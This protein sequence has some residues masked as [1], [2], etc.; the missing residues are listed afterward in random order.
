MPSIADDIFVREEA[1]DL[2]RR[3]RMTAKHFFGVR[4][5]KPCAILP[6]HLLHVRT[7]I[8]ACEK[9]MM[10]QPATLL[11]SSKEAVHT[12]EHSVLERR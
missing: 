6:L 1:D 3:S 7:H 8:P 12:A 4:R 11:K 10:A 2:L 5:A 9:A